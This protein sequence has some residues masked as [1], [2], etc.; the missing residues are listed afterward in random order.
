[1]KANLLQPSEFPVSDNITNIAQQTLPVIDNRARP[2]PPDIINDEIVN[3][4]KILIED[5]K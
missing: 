5:L 4:F 3:M 1:M 2:S